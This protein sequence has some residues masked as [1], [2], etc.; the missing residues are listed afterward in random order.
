MEQ[1]QWF[2]RQNDQQFGPVGR[3]EIIN[4]IHMGLLT[5]DSYVWTQGMENWQTVGQTPELAAF[6]PI[7]IAPAKPTSVTV[8]GTLNII[9]GGMNLLCSPFA[10]LSVFIPQPDPAFQLSAGMRLYTLVSVILSMIMAVVLIA[11][12]IGLLKLRSWA[13]QTAYVY[14][15]IAFVWGILGII[16]SAVLLSTSFSGMSENAMPAMIGGIVG[17]MCGGLIGLVYPLLL[18]IYMRKPHV[19]EACNK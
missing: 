13:R 19:I 2:Y 7:G 17:G 11:C 6:S 4:Q 14:G 18:I 5:P 3:D 15:W 10:I 9:F 1:Q 12:G 16:I 8:L